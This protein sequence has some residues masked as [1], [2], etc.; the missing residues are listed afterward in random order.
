MRSW[1]PCVLVLL[2]AACA[3]PQ[4]VVIDG[5]RVPRVQLGYTDGKYFAFTH[6]GA[7]PVPAEQRPS[8]VFDGGRINGVICG[9]DFIYDVWYRNGTVLLTGFVRR[10]G[11]PTR[12]VIASQLYVRDRNGVREIS[13]YVGR[14]VGYSTI[15]LQLTPEALHGRVAR[16]HY[17]LAASEGDSYTGTIEQG[18]YTGPFAGL[19]RQALWAMP[20]EDQA[21]LLSKVLSCSHVFPW[22]GQSGR[23][24]APIEQVYFT[25]P[26]AIASP[27]SLAPPAGP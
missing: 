20:P 2:L 6:K 23:W 18:G 19:G 17:D 11:V 27:A 1:A 16:R 3:T 7:L 10:Y 5:K 12:D 24:S 25:H 21:V 26:G 4:T 15:D 8:N 9:L 22:S 13:G 14:T